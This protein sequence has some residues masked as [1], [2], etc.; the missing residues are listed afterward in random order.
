MVEDTWPGD[1][2]AATRAGL[3]SLYRAVA[4]PGRNDPETGHETLATRLPDAWFERNEG[5]RL[6]GVAGLSRRPTGHRFTA[7][8]P[9][10]FGWCPWDGLFLPEIL[11]RELAI[12]SR[13]PVTGEPIAVRASDVAVE[14]LAPQSAVLVLA[15][16]DRERF[17]RGL[18]EVFCAGVRLCID[19]A[20]GDAFAGRAPGRVVLSVEDG[21]A[22]GRHR[23]RVVFGD[24]PSAVA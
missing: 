21:F 18:R 10:C 6:V 1:L 17:A 3:R 11:G 16:V 7:G 2:D 12:E 20:T 22:L 5:G 13:C 14:A 9:G 24:A 23:N 4:D 8:A 15:R 19:R